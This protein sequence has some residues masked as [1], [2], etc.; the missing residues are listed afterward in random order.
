MH[1][2]YAC[3]KHCEHLPVDEPDQHPFPCE[4]GC[5]D[6]PPADSPASTHVLYRG[7]EGSLP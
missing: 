3:C 5:N 6:T 2:T 4:Q 1:E 7:T